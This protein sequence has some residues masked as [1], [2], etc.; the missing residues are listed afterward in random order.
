MGSNL[1]E[2]FPNFKY[3]IQFEGFDGNFDN[4]E[5]FPLLKCPECGDKGMIRVTDDSNRDQICNCGKVLM[6]DGVKKI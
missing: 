1:S 2:V 6:K 4:E 5:T 3:H